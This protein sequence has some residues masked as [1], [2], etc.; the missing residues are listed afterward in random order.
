VTQTFP[1]GNE[2]DSYTDTE[3]NTGVPA[4]DRLGEEYN[5]DIE[6]IR[7]YSD[8]EEI[9]EVADVPRSGMILDRFS[10]SSPIPF[11]ETGDENVS[12]IHPTIIHASWGFPSGQRHH[13]RS[14]IPSTP[15]LDLRSLSDGNNRPQLHYSHES[16]YQPQAWEREREAEE[17]DRARYVDNEGRNVDVLDARWDLNPDGESEVWGVDMGQ[18]WAAD[19]YDSESADKSTEGASFPGR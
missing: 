2:G 19:P 12:A 11:S 8:E 14:A 1:G 18:P 6:Q 13:P 9:G 16:F 15:G 7:N 10:A 5:R 3:E 17:T 4:W